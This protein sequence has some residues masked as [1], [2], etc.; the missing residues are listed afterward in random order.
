MIR[1]D[2]GRL[3]EALY[4]LLDNAVKYSRERGE[5][6]LM[7]QRS[8]QQIVL[9]VSDNGNGIGKE[10]LPPDFR[11]FYRAI[12]REATTAFAAPVSASRSSN[13]SRNSTAAMSKLRV[14]S[15]KGRRF[16]WL[17]PIVTQT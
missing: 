2:R 6:T 12:K 3:Q 9:S 15:A 16:A 13:I 1:A 7:A 17:L 11:A 10:D 5:I 4:N 14:N 8:E